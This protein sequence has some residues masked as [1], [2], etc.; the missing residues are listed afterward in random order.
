MMDLFVGRN[1]AFGLG[2]S[3]VSPAAASDGSRGLSR[4]LMA[5]L[6]IVALP[7]TRSGTPLPAPI[8]S[9]IFLAGN[10][11]YMD[12]YRNGTSNCIDMVHK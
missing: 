3:Q 5:H 1:R 7:L 2:S 8:C 9:S 11:D 4:N 10:W 12:W 6:P